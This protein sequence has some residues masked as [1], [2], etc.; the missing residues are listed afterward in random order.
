MHKQHNPPEDDQGMKATIYAGDTFEE[1]KRDYIWWLH[2]A[3]QVTHLSNAR[4]AGVIACLATK[5]RAFDED[6]AWF[7]D[8][9]ILYLSSTVTVLD[10]WH[11]FLKYKISSLSNQNKVFHKL[12]TVRQEFEVRL[13]RHLEELV[14]IEARRIAYPPWGTAPG[15]DSQAL[16]SAYEVVLDRLQKLGETVRNEHVEAAKG[17]TLDFST[18]EDTVRKSIGTSVLETHNNVFVGL[19]DKEASKEEINYCAVSQA[20]FILTPALQ[21]FLYAAT[22]DEFGDEWF[23]LGVRPFLSEL[24]RRHVSGRGPDEKVMRRLDAKI[25]LQ[26]I[27]IPDSWDRVF[28]NYLD[29]DALEYIGGVD[30]ARVNW[31]HYS[32]GG[33]TARK[34]SHTLNS[35]IH[36]VEAIAPELVGRMQQ[37]KNKIK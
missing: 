13:Q 8:A 4:I 14:E 23:K 24:D 30:R 37:I 35:M 29:R 1:L 7:L 2:L 33:F 11:W 3:R 21:D 34:A 10:R 16:E 36:L 12:E 28:K 25:C 15:R 17:V 6:L 27:R 32:S 5:R 22:R 19:S 31:A 20:F 26:V 18:L 9:E